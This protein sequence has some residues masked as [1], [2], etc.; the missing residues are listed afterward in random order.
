MK[1][2]RGTNVKR[3]KDKCGENEIPERAESE[4]RGKI[5]ERNDWKTR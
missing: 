3:G 4:V 1:D 5:E 2:E